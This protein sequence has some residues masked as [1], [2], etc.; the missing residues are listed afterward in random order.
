MS[1]TSSPLP[2]TP[3]Y[4]AA[5]RASCL[6]TS[7]AL[8]L[9]PNTESMNAFLRTLDQASFERLR[10][11]H[12]LSFPLR[13]PT[14]TA[15]INFLA[16]LA[17]LNA[18]SGYRTVFH[19]ATGIGAYQNVVRLMMGLYIAG[20]EE[21]RV[22]GAAALTAKGM[23]ALSEAK[24]VELLGVSV[25]EEKQ[26]ES[27]PG[28][29]VGVRGGEMFEA[30][31]MILSTV[32]G[33][34]KTLLAN[35]FA[36]MGAYL[37]HLLQDTKSQNLNDQQATD[38]LVRQIASTFPEFRDTHHIQP[39]DTDVYVFKRIFFLLHSLYV[40]F[41]QHPDLYIPNT[42]QTL[43]MF[44]DNVLPTLCVWLHLFDQPAPPAPD[45]MHTLY[46]WM[47]H[48]HQHADLARDV[49]ESMPNNMPGP[50]LSPDETYALRAATLNL[51]AALV[52]RAKVLAKQD[53]LEWLHRLNEVDLDGYLW[54][55]A[56]DDP[57]LRKVPRFSFAS[58]HF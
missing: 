11:Q 21:D 39:I 34:G 32:Q 25:H 37:V 6:A 3:D 10:T 17:L 24:V 14:H 23:A 55:V 12:G 49:L 33:V 29:T 7:T 50:T 19:K 42:F 2:S 36:S 52:E 18:Y 54:A 15:E 45:S 38:Y 35:N 44:V 9:T 26:H 5:T 30:V 51:G 8:G 41:G 16:I 40:K 46:H 53:G 20:G 27:L 58:I 31:Q 43:P 1:S 47:A 13:F 48:S 22:V 28:V 57:A 56:K 4:I